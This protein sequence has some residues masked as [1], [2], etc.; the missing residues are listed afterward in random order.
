MRIPSSFTTSS[1]VILIAN[2]WKSLN[3]NVRALEDRAIILH[4]NPSNTEVHRKVGEWFDDVEVYEYVERLLA[5]I[6]FVSM[7]HYCKG[8]Q[9]RRAGLSDWRMS[10]LQ[11]VIADPRLAALVA[12]QA[13]PT[14][15]S[16]RERENGF[17]AQTGCSRAT[18][19]RL[20][21]LVVAPRAY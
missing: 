8:S 14:M 9:L 13:D 6:P 15:H 1:S 4:F 12:V 20:K 2:Q 7:R 5:T 19:Y 3:A 16:E 21:S 18:Y 17:I 10:L 11:M